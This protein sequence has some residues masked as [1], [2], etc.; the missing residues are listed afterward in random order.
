M[1][2]ILETHILLTLIQDKVDNLNRSTR[3]WASD[4]KTFN[5]Q[6]SRTF[7]DDFCQMFKKN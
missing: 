7:T 2:K 1:G 6:K 4:Q 5:K 3:D